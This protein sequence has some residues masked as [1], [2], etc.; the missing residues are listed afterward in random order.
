MDLTESATAAV[1]EG[2]SQF[3]LDLYAALRSE[4]GNLFFSPY[5][6]S[7]ALAMTYA[8][9]RGETAEQMAAVLRFPFGEPE[10][11]PAF[12]ALARALQGGGEPGEYQLS[13]ANALWGQAGY[14][15]P[16]SF[17]ELT[18]RYYGAGLR[19]LDFA[20]GTEAARGVINAWVEQQT[21]GRIKDLL[22]PG[23]LKSLTR[24]VLTNAIYFKGKWAE[25]FSPRATREEP[26]FTEPEGEVPVPMM[27]QTGIMKYFEHDRFQ[28]LELP[29]AGDD[30]S[31]VVLLP[32]EANGLPEL[33]QALTVA[34][35]A[36]WLPE[37]RMD[38]VEVH[39]PRFRMTAAFLLNHVLSGMGMRFAFDQVHADFY[40]MDG[41]REPR[42]CISA[43]VHK[44]FV[45][46]NEEGTEAA[47]ATAVVLAVRAM[48]HQPPVFRADHPFVFL[49]RDTRSGSILF[50][51][52]VADPR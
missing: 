17:Q 27:R 41:G 19:E 49:I 18:Q 32:R 47:A 38:K 36:R 31:M 4:D 44:A 43:V 11:H 34:N 33:E 14:G 15:F 6:L 46:V 30:L 45:E 51:G 23:V 25:P 50:M 9:A 20:H 13:I 28:A 2:N 48:I 40:G 26:F 42:L 7:T 12:A 5:S 3:A 22:Q 10:L 37:L 1:V 39:L 24:L 52:R 8:G 21:Q 16:A 35:L 29:Y